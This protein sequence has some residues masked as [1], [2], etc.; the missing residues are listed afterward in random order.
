MKARIETSMR[1]T[2]PTRRGDPLQSV[3]DIKPGEA[4]GFR[5]PV[6]TSQTPLITKPQPMIVGNMAGP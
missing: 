1:P 3:N 5:R 2:L 6:P 4:P